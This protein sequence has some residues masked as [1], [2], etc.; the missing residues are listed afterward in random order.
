M[1]FRF[2]CVFMV[3]RNT[4]PTALFA[5]HHCDHDPTQDLLAVEKRAGKDAASFTGFTADA[6]TYVR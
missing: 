6:L 3:S 1:W 5:R 4:T 2:R